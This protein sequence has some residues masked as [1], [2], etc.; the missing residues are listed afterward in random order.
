MSGG[1]KIDDHSAWMGSRDKDTILPMGAKHK[2]ESPAT[3]AGEVSTY[4]DTTQA[5]KGQQETG[6]GKIKKNPNKTNYRE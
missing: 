2:N 1:R 3:G 4:V 6:I 5:I